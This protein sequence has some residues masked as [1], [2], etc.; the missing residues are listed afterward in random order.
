MPWVDRV[1]TRTQ[2]F[3][4]AIA[5]VITLSASQ[6]TQLSDQVNLILISKLII[7]ITRVLQEQ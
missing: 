6:M 3:L 7:D 1:T 5:N 4:S 2:G